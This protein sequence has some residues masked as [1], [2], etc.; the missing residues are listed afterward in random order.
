MQI[1]LFYLYF[2]FS[3]Q[4]KQAFRYIN[5]RLLNAAAF[6][7]SSD[8]YKHRSKPLQEHDLLWLWFLS[9]HRVYLLHR[10]CCL[11]FVIFILNCV[12]ISSMARAQRSLGKTFVFWKMTSL[13]L[14]LWVF[15]FLL[16]TVKVNVN[17]TEKI[18]LCNR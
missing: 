8:I 17:L 13:S 18:F 7:H 12:W 16:L 11:V 2:L 4:N 10:G 6:N 5:S 15:L 9:L 14:L 1:G 3:L